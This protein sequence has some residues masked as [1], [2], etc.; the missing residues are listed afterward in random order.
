MTAPELEFAIQ[1]TVPR[2]IQAIAFN[3]E[4]GVDSF[5]YRISVAA[6]TEVITLER[7]GVNSALIKALAARMEISSTRLIR[8]LGIPK[9]SAE[10]QIAAGKV[11]RGCGGQAAIAMV[12][13]LGIA[14]EIVE[15]STAPEAKDFDAARWLGQW[16]ERPQ[17]ALGG[18]KPADFLDTPTGVEIVTRLLRSIESGSYQ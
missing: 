6:P 5:S 4:E 14:K 1:H 7:E 9:S 15:R 13:L 17:P 8:I 12:K 11:I 3:V 2:H 18:A 16:I 10:R